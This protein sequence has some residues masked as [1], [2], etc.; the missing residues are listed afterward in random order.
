[1]LKLKYVTL[2]EQSWNEQGY[3]WCCVLCGNRELSLLRMRCQACGGALDAFYD[4]SRVKVAADPSPLARYADL[5]P[6]RSPATWLGEG[7]TG[8]IHA[9]RL[10]RRLGMDALFLK[11]ESANPTRSTKDRLAPI[12]LARF[13]ELGVHRVSL[14]STGNTSTAY[15]RG[16]QLLGEFE[17]HIFVGKEFHHR[18]NY[19]DHPAVKTYVL[20]GGFDSAGVAAK[21]FAAANHMPFEG[22]FFNA[23]RREGLKLAYLEAFDQ[24]PMPPRF[25]FQAVSS[26]MGMLGAY[27][28]AVEY[29]ALGRINAIPAFVAVQ[30]ETCAPMAAAFA[31][32]SSVIQPHHVVRRPT[33]P[34]A[35][36]LRGDPTPTYPYVE[37]VCRGTGGAIHAATLDRIC[38][39]RNLLAELEGL[40]VCSASATALA[41][42]MDL[43]E[44]GT[45]AA[46]APVLV[47]LTG[48]DR[49]FAPVPTQFSAYTEAEA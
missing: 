18:L 24:M 39:A 11:D 26:G 3:R 20:D 42:V 41:G 4:L 22:G 21:Q 29:R 30:Q 7:N 35:A 23:A 45:I 8:C 44:R 1:M 43:R 13:A 16:A 9:E 40:H 19:V 38:E 37:A 47:N 15:A 48:A 31:E 14:S 32:N 34:A 27:K 25:V 36:I 17:L 28:G 12:A 10:G 33:G 46:E 5:L 49:P 6:L 2:A